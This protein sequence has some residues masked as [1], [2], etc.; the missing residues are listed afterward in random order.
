MY[1]DF[2]ATPRPYHF[3]TC[4]TI[5]LGRLALMFHDMPQQQRCPSKAPAKYRILLLFGDAPK[6]T[7]VALSDHFMQFADRQVREGRYGSTSEVL[8][9][10]LRLPEE[11]ET[12]LQ[13][14]RS[15]LADGEAS[16]VD[17]G[18]AFDGFV[19]AVDD[20]H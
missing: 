3:W 14:L 19:A 9:A 6:N 20:I 16:G 17:D 8:R 13:A 12:R 11:R 15:A 10:G 4:L 2:A 7:S 18:F 1:A 5:D